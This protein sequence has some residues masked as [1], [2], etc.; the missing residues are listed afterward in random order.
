LQVIWLDGLHKVKVD[1]GFSGLLPGS[2]PGV[3][4]YSDEKGDPPRPL[5]LE[6]PGNLVAAHVRKP[7]IQQGNVE[8]IGLGHLNSILAIVN[9]LY[10]V[11]VQTKK[12]GHALRAIRIVLHDQDS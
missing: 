4:R 2:L 5:L 10:L 7:E 6:M 3:A 1:A 11:T 8:L 12:Y 9:D